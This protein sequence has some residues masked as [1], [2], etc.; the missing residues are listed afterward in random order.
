MASVSNE[1][2]ITVSIPPEVAATHR[3]ERAVNLAEI[4]TWLTR[5]EDEDV[6]DMPRED[7]ETDLEVAVV[8][9]V[10]GLLDEIRAAHGA[11]DPIVA[12]RDTADGPPLPL[13]TRVATAVRIA[14]EAV[15]ARDAAIALGYNDG[16]TVGE[17]AES[18]CLLADVLRGKSITVEHRCA[19]PAKCPL[20]LAVAETEPTPED[21][22]RGVAA[23]A[24][25]GSREATIARLAERDPAL[26]ATVAH[27][28]IT[29]E[30]RHVEPVHYAPKGDPDRY[31]TACGVLWKQ[32]ARFQWTDDP[33]AVRGCAT[34]ENG[35]A[36]RQPLTMIVAIARNGVIGKAGG[37]PWRIP[38]DLRHF[39]RET[40]GHALIVGRRTAETLPP[41]DYR[42]VLVV[43]RAGST[44]A[45]SA[46]IW[47]VVSSFEAALDAARGVDPHPIVIGGAEVYR[48]ALP[49]VTRILLTEI[50]ADHEGDVFFHLDRTGWRETERRAGETP[51]VS[52][53]TLERAPIARP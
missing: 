4:E 13:A 19:D 11:L 26:A 9:Y 22:A 41:L 17:Q 52:F 15:A 1:K 35:K 37:L 39:K 34:C 49:F 42:R 36:P 53:V 10:P 18:I 27:A 33:D 45:D 5:L 2:T 46:R 8:S 51:G 20:C 25:M 38:E 44:L 7:L 14:Q 16:R 43:S 12:R 6:D 32:D 24:Q 28:G 21:L 50:D 30:R 48:A 23:F 31:P 40:W 47:G 3:P 29:E